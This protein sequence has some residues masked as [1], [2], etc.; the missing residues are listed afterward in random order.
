M[1]KPGNKK[2]SKLKSI[3]KRLH[4]LSGRPSV[5][6]AKTPNTSTCQSPDCSLHPIYVGQSRRRYLITPELA[7]HPLL[8]VLLRHS[9][10]G[11]DGGAVVGCEVVLFDH[12]LWMLENGEGGSESVDELVEYYACC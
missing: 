10:G 3:L 8:Q 4:S 9:D 7:E 5:A 6:T 1:P 2:L 12:L 11:D